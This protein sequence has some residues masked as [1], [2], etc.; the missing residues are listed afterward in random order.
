MMDET[1]KHSAEAS[2]AL[3]ARFSGALLGTMVGDA[4]GAPMEG[5]DIKHLN[6]TLSLL[7]KLPKNSPYRGLCDH[8]VGVLGGRL[9]AG[10][11]F[12]TD[13]T[14]MTFAVA[15]SLIRCSG[16]EGK[17]LATR[18]SERFDGRRSY[19]PGVYSVLISL[20]R[21]ASWETAA[22]HLFGGQGSLGNGGAAR[23]APVALYYHDN[24]PDRLWQAAEISAAVTHTHR[25]GRQGAALQAVAI[26]V[27]L[28]WNR[29]K[30]FDALRFLAVVRETLRADADTVYLS[31][32]D[33][34][35]NLLRRPETTRE[36]VAN[37]LGTGIESHR[38]VPTALW[39]FLSQPDSFEAAVLAAIRLGGDTDTIGAMTG[40]ISGALH[41]EEGIPPHWIQAM[42]N[43]PEDGRDYLRDL[44]GWLHN[45]WLKQK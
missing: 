27:A 35:A 45:A 22:Q 29:D 31:A 32:L 42:E 12:Y 39:A 34:V 41:G 26:S 33:T 21:G 13:D 11:A 1:G 28:R 16:L 17:D 30:P 38:S 20:R 23:V 9:A 36:D 10:Q 25:L 19:G 4:L 44:A 14:Q 6:D 18:L 5:W 43:N 24:E 37:A 8:R 2:H 15:E 3:R 40:A 7:E